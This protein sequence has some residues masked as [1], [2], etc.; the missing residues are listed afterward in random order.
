MLNIGRYDEQA[1]GTT[2]A[3]AGDRKSSVPTTT[4]QGTIDP[5]EKL[6]TDKSQK[7]HS[8]L[9]QIINPHGKKYDNEGYGQTAHDAG[10]SSSSQKAAAAA[11]DDSSKPLS[12]MRP[13]QNLVADKQVESSRTEPTQSQT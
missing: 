10:Q 11:E 9:R 4:T 8:I 1:Y 3:T 6:E 13:D 12:L 7:E 2:A 5:N